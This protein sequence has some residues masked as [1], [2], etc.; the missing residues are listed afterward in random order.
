MLYVFGSRESEA[1]CE[2]EA[3]HYKAMELEH[4]HQNRAC[5]IGEEKAD[6]GNC[7]WE[8]PIPSKIE[9]CCNEVGKDIEQISS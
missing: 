3:D 5:W 9:T 1:C 7:H 6:R 4:G 2:D 8:Q